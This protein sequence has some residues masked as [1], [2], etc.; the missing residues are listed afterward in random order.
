MIRKNLLKTFAFSICMSALFTG[1]VYAQSTGASSPAFEGT[2]SQ[3]DSTLFEK[4]SQI[5]QHL[6]IDHIKDIEKKN[7]KVIYTGV[8][9][10]YVEVG[11]SPYSEENAEY[12]FDIVGKDQVKVVGAEEA[13]LLNHQDAPDAVV[14]TDNIS[15]VMDIGKDTP[16][17]YNNGD[18]TLIDDSLTIEEREQK[19]IAEEEFT[20]QIESVRNEELGEVVPDVI[21]QSDLVQDLQDEDVAITSDKDSEVNIVST[22]DTL[23]NTSDNTS[24]NTQATALSRPGIIGMIAGGIIILGGAAFAKNKKLDKEKK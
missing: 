15:P 3:E 7:F 18:D 24:E 4:Q 9:H 17:S 20:I 5:D 19:A 16:V 21:S 8:A 11:I 22:K 10:G 14:E 12:I 6:F 1:Q 23:E 13:V 2:I